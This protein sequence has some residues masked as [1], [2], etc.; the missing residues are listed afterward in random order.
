MID[1]HESCEV[2]R[3]LGHHLAVPS[4]ID[5]GMISGAV[6]SPRHSA[7]MTVLINRSTP[8]VRWKRSRVDQSS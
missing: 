2:L 8:R 1:F 7:W 5:P 3:Q 4:G 6:S